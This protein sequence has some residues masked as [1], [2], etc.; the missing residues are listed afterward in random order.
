MVSRTFHT[1]LGVRVGVASRQF[2]QRLVDACRAAA[3]AVTHG[4]Q[5]P[6]GAASWLDQ[7]IDN[8]IDER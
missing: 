1:M 4:R 6:T 5:S 3:R 7:D 8:V 2:S